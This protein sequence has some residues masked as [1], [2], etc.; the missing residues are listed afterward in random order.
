M[1]KTLHR[2]LFR[3]LPPLMLLAAAPA[4]AHTDGVAHSHLQGFWDG[5]VHPWTGPD[6]L[7]AMLAVGMWSAL[8]L[9]RPWHAPLAFAGSLLVGAVLAMATGWMM[10]AVEAGIT[11][12]LAVLGL[13]VALRLGMPPV[14]GAVTAA[15]LAFSHG[16]AHG[17]E[18]Q[19]VAALAGMAVSTAALH[20]MGLA[21]GGQLR[22]AATAPWLGR[23]G[24][25]LVGGSLA[26]LALA[27]LGG[28]A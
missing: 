12:S 13:L 1:H 9:K 10:P 3:T 23:L 8:S 20:G 28:V 7:A 15:V 11:V 19:G 5:V 25:G 24:R 26:A 4:M 27:R 16:A 14:A 22:Q 18:L 2:T 17:Q 6:H 21:L